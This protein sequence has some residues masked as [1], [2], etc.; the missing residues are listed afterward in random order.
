MLSYTVYTSVFAKVHIYHFIICPLL[1][2]IQGVCILIA[3]LKKKKRKKIDPCLMPFRSLVAL[4]QFGSFSQFGLA[5][6]LKYHV[7]A[8]PAL[9]DMS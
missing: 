6:V 7:G 3:S 5:I 8:W 9:R 2:Q 4:L 1:I